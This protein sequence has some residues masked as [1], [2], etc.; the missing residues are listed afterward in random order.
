MYFVYIVEAADG[1]LYTGITTDIQRRL[2]EH[3]AGKIGSKYLRAR[4]PIALKYSRN[5][6]DRSSASK[7]EARIKK[8]KREEKL[9]L[10][11]QR[12]A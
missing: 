5:F 11:E 2:V 7:E 1:T 9:S 3:N 8:L 6:P 4:L 10:I 12:S